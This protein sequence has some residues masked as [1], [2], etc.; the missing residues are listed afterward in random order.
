MKIIEAMKRIKAIDA[1]IGVHA[2]FIS[3]NFARLTTEEAP[4][5]EETSQKVQSAHQ[6]VVSLIQ[7]KNSLQAR[8]QK[9][10]I[11][12]PVTV[13]VVNQRGDREA[14]TKTISEWVFRRDRGVREEQ[15]LVS[16][17]EER[18]LKSKVGVQTLSNGEKVVVDVARA[19]EPDFIQQ[20]SMALASEPLEIDAQLEIINATVDLV[21]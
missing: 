15:S 8:I 9:T 6:A 3:K 16:L 10:N 13:S 4:F 11:T 20:R 12:T 21:D 17:Y 18:F 2:N 14:V 19:Y 7:E 1:Q 5:G